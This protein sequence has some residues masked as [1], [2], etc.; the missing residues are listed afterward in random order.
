MVNVYTNN[1]Q[2]NITESLM[3]AI[4]VNN[5]ELLLEG[6]PAKKLW[7]TPYDYKDLDDEN[8][9]EEKNKK[10]IN[11][12]AQYKRNE[13]AA[14]DILSAEEEAEKKRAEDKEWEEYQNKKYNDSNIEGKISILRDRVGEV[15]YDNLPA[16]IKDEINNIIEDESNNEKYPDLI[17]KLKDETEMSKEDFEKLKNSNDN[18]EDKVNSN[19][20]KLN[21][22]SNEELT[23]P[24]D[25]VTYAPLLKEINDIELQSKIIIRRCQEVIEHTLGIA[26]RVNNSQPSN[27]NMDINNVAT[28]NNNSS[29]NKNYQNLTKYGKQKLEK[30]NINQQEPELGL[31]RTSNISDTSDDNTNTNNNIFKKAANGA[32]KIWDKT[33]ATS[34]LALGGFRFDT[35]VKNKADFNTAAKWFLDKQ[36]K[37]EKTHIDDMLRVYRNETDIIN[38]LK[39]DSELISNGE[40]GSS[41][42]RK[43]SYDANVEAVEKFNKMVE[44]FLTNTVFRLNVNNNPKFNSLVQAIR[45][46]PNLNG[47]WKIDTISNVKQFDVR[48]NI[49]SFTNNNTKA[50]ACILIISPLFARGE[51]IL[52]PLIKSFGQQMGNA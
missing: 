23:T 45:L 14:N 33:K 50:V 30:Y 35:F 38:K 13:K 52:K 19:K 44:N 22:F 51:E 21:N 40:N 18:L 41:A 32:D 49:I 31:G 9:E 3:E 12:I 15:G 47:K 36:E 10:E 8:S 7:T 26:G 1:G 37:T 43:L 39:N 5:P 6:E 16:N 2:F 11:R 48:E 17:S 4:K 28:S 29:E 24:A 20:E 42:S 27:V 34:L 46:D 25:C